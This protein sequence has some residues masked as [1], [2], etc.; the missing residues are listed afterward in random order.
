VTTTVY[1]TCA[2]ALTVGGAKIADHQ[3]PNTENTP[4]TA[5]TVGGKM[6]SL[7]MFLFSLSLYHYYI[8]VFIYLFIYI[9]IYKLF[10]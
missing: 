4:P 10:S 2:Q 7:S 1:R 3:I 6:A 5:E 8:Y 9:Y